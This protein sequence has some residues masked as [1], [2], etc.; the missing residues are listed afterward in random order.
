MLAPLLITACDTGTANYLAPALPHLRQ[1]W[2]AFVH[3]EASEVF[4]QHGLPCKLVERCDWDGLDALGQEILSTDGYGAVIAGTS[5]GPTLDKA[6]T[7]AA[8]SKGLRSIAIIEH[9]SRY[10]ERF[11]RIADGR[12]TDIDG[13]LPDEIWVND[14]TAKQEAAAAGLP[15]LSLRVVGQPHLE[16]QYGR[17]SR[18]VNVVRDKSAVFVSERFADH[19][20]RGTPL[21]LG[22]DEFKAVEGLIAAMAPDYRLII[23]LHP[24]D[25]PNKYDYLAARGV[26]AEVIRNCDSVQMITSA[27]HIVGMMSMLLLEAALVRDDVV[28]FMPGG[29]PVEFVGNRIG[30][31]RVATTTLELATILAAEPAASTPDRGFGR[32]FAGSAQRVT[33]ALGE[34][35]ACV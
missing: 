19:F 32:R 24:Q 22:F 7:L 30:A 8:R 14:E 4:A 26:R 34:L 33:A 25:E 9:W 31:T 3:G 17:L 13:F 1:P 15:A 35:T 20:L 27:G 28:S 18:H 16:A 2:K 12:C 10:R 6:V 23:K 21:D 11:A 29:R 5:W